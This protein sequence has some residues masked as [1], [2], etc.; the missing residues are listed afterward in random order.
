ML[1]RD[2]ISGS[3]AEEKRKEFVEHLFRCPACFDSY[4]AHVKE[5][6]R[7][8]KIFLYQRPLWGPFVFD[9]ETENRLVKDMARNALEAR[10]N[11]CKVF[12]LKYEKSL[13][14]VAYTVQ[15]RVSAYLRAKGED[16]DLLLSP[17]QTLLPAA[18][19][20]KASGPLFLIA[21]QANHL[22]NF[23]EVLEQASQSYLISLAGWPEDE[24]G[25]TSLPFNHEIY[26]LRFSPDKRK[27]FQRK[28]TRE[29]KRITALKR[30]GTA[31]LY[32]AL[33]DSLAIPTPE[34]LLK[35]LADEKD[36]VG[37]VEQSL[38]YE[39]DIPG[40]SITYFTTMG[41]IIARRL[42]DALSMEVEETGFNRIVEAANSG[43]KHERY[44]LIRMFHTLMLRGQLSLCRD[45][46]YRH[47][48]KLAS[49]VGKG[50]TTERL[51]WG[52]IFHDLYLYRQAEQAFNKGLEADP[53]NTFL[54]HGYARLLASERKYDQADSKFNQM[55][56]LSPEN[57][58]LWQS[59]AEIQLKKGAIRQAEAMFNRA[60]EIAPQNVYT[61]VSYGNFLMQRRNLEQARH[62]LTVARRVSPSNSY[63]LNSLGVMEMRLKRYDKARDL[64]DRV[65]STE[66]G[67][68]PT[69]HAVGQMDKERGHLKKASG[70]F[71]DVLRV[72][73]DN[74]HSLHALGE[75]AMEEARVRGNRS[76][77]K[78]AQSHLEKVLS[79]DSDNIESII[80]LTVLYRRDGKLKKA[81]EYLALAAKIE[82]E[83]PYTLV[84]EGRIYAV[85]GNL[86]A[87]EECFWK[88]LAMDEANVPALVAL[89]QTKAE[90]NL[91]QARDFFRKA[92]RLEPKNVIT[93]NSWADVEMEAGKLQRAEKLLNL[94]LKIDTANAYTLSALARLFEK[95]GDRQQAR[96]FKEKANS[97]F[98]K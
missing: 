81:R 4:L 86:V 70:I 87:A 83:S 55:Q 20:D 71:N 17:E 47:N 7:E 41:D 28:F 48:Q 92:R 24:W 36:I 38:I 35:N 90:N 18:G 1:L 50:D 31:Y 76:L 19:L 94:S 93:L 6:L 53:E 82:P 84:N 23:M 60:L 32:V 34:S 59:W 49:L 69:L 25:E 98:F 12:I 88:G 37:A 68:V 13:E 10:N 57:V 97:V 62:Q 29:F 9:F 74:L 2:F 14:K 54:L 85:E 56:K 95:K 21:P 78:T 27:H 46:F 22:V 91:K 77:Y 51:L 58:F 45:L 52:K 67:N 8:K 44:V 65:L 15:L 61:R 16:I 11:G 64:F 3:L 79:I 5:E 75:I 96:Y 66:P 42:V 43:L 26:S 39:S 80:S 63:A 73:P 30:A 72:Y 89:A 40:S 33:L